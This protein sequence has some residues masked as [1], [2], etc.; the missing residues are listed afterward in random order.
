MMQFRIHY[1]IGDYEDFID[2]DGETIEE[3]QS[4]AYHELSTRGVKSDNAW[5]EEIKGVPR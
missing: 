1:S 2:L 5:S 4:Q 3:I